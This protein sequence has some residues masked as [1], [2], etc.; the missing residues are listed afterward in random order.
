MSHIFL[1]YS[2]IEEFYRDEKSFKYFKDISQKDYER[3]KE[4]AI[5][6]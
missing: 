4:K 5:F 6:I 1:P 2:T 3:L